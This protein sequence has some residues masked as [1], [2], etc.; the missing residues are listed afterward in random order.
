MQEARSKERASWFFDQSSN[1]D[2]RRSQARLLSGEPN[3]TRLERCVAPDG[4]LGSDFFALAN[5]TIE[6]VR[7][8]PESPRFVN[9]GRI[10]RQLQNT[11]TPRKTPN[12]VTRGDG[13]P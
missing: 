2:A 11:R 7:R 8:L 9:I 3:T 13:S 10:A 12:G 6:L 1:I 4:I 5:A